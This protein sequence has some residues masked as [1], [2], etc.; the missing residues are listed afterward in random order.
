MNFIDDAGQVLFNINQTL[1]SF[2]K[3]TLFLVFSFFIKNMPKPSGLKVRSSYSNYLHILWNMV[4]ASSVIIFISFTIKPPYHTFVNHIVYITNDVIACKRPFKFLSDLE[5]FIMTDMNATVK[6]I[7]YT[8]YC[9][10]LITYPA[11]H[12]LYRI[13]WVTILLG[14]PLLLSYLMY[15]I[16]YHMI[17]LITHDKICFVSWTNHWSIPNL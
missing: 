8:L 13:L 9:M 1:K 12:I 4:Y 16:F 2:L 3:I 6:P 15:C 11:S 10:Y 5:L 14:M 17:Q 7:L